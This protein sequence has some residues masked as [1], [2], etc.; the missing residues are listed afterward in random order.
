M[1]ANISPRQQKFLARLVEGRSQAQAARESGYHPVTA[2]RLLQRH[3]IRA[4]LERL[5]A[6]AEQELLARLP[7]LVQQAVDILEKA[8]GY[9]NRPA[10]QIMAAR[11]ILMLAERLAKK[12]NSVTVDV[13]P[14]APASDPPH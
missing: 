1:N 9:N 7:R 12:S 10:E 5:R 3:E 8:L 2:C 11:T 13:T 4:E 6:E 14:D